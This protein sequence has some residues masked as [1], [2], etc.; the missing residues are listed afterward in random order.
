MLLPGTHGKTTTSAM[1]AHI[2]QTA[3]L[4]PTAIIGGQ[5]NT[6]G[7]NAWLGNG[8]YLVAEADESD[9]SFLLLHPEIGVFT[10]IDADHLDYYQNINT[11]ETAL[12]SV[13]K[14]SKRDSYYLR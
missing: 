7:L 8:R 1:I 3:K 4:K 12:C 6:S 2:L 11:I 9:G 14:S 13:F 5:I 10:N